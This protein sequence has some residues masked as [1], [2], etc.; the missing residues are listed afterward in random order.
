MFYFSNVDG[1]FLTGVSG[2]I[3]YVPTTFHGMISI[4]F[5]NPWNGAAKARAHWAWGRD[6]YNHMYNTA[7]PSIGRTDLDGV[8]AITCEFNLVPNGP[9]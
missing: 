8:P 5:S 1:G 3:E 4:A 2:W 7:H 6:S 9:F